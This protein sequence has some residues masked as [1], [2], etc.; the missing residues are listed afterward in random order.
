MNLRV[1][2]WDLL[3]DKLLGPGFWISHSTLRS[4][5]EHKRLLSCSS[6]GFPGSA[7]LTLV[8]ELSCP[9]QLAIIG[10]ASF[11]GGGG[12]GSFTKHK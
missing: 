2:E 4:G 10:S 12:G 3:H 8:R 7:A 9:S 5:A 6:G 1:S 11:A